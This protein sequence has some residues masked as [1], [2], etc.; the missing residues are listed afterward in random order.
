MAEKS[1][2]YLRVEQRAAGAGGHSLLQGASTQIFH[3][4]R[5]SET[6]HKLDISFA[7]AGTTLPDGEH[8][9]PNVTLALMAGDATKCLEV[10]RND[11]SFKPQFSICDILLLCFA[12]DTSSPTSIP[13]A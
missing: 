9:W 1:G 4:L 5:G 8:D 3:V 6:A 12:P 7:F 13:H 2:G 11:D 10:N